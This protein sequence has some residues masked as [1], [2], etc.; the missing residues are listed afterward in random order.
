M[1]ILFFSTVQS[2]YNNTVFTHLLTKYFLNADMWK[3]LC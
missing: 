2:F 3:A 1:T